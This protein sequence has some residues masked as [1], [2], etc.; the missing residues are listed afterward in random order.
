MQSKI[1][2]APFCCFYMQH[3]NVLIFV[4]QVLVDRVTPPFMPTSEVMTTFTAT[5]SGQ[6][7]PRAVPQRMSY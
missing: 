2:T 4:I 1:E 3:V 6:Q 7:I 5:V